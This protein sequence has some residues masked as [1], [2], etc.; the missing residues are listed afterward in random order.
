[1]AKVTYSA[2]IDS[3]SGA[4]SKPG[5]NGQHSCEKMLLATH[6]KAATQ[7]SDC[8]RLYLR[9]KVV[10]TTPLK[11]KEVSIR[12]RFQAVRAMVAA[13]KEDLTK[14]TQDQIDFLAQKDLPLARLRQ[15]VRRVARLIVSAC[16]KG[17]SAFF[18]RFFC[19]FLAH[20]A[21]K[22]YLCIVKR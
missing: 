3:V 7:S 5:K 9:K 19:F 6:R 11:P 8:N 10:R 20:I 15:R 21:K 12:Q 13:R 22:Q 17:K 18:V 4:L 16:R 1:M 14:V 2:G